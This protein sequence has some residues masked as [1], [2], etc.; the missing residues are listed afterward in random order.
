[1]PNQIIAINLVKSSKI[2]ENYKKYKILETIF[3]RI[4]M[5]HCGANYTRVVKKISYWLSDEIRRLKI[6]RGGAM[7]F[8]TGMRSPAIFCQATGEVSSIWPVLD[9]ISNRSLWSVGPARCKPCGSD[10]PGRIL[11]PE[12]YGRCIWQ[13]HR[14]LFR[15]PGWPR[16]TNQGRQPSP[17]ASARPV[18]FR[19]AHPKGI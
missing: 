13:T 12:Q 2:T 18:K 1:M 11:S 7:R 14:R 19:L 6:Y 9:A 3:K 5:W 4:F 10:R 15:R 17:E 8:V 16:C